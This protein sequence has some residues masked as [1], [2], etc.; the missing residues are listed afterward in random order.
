MTVQIRNA[1]PG[2]YRF[3]NDKD[4]LFLL[5]E[6]TSEHAEIIDLSFY[7]ESI[8]IGFMKYTIDLSRIIETVDNKIGFDTIFK[9]K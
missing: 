7:H 3:M 4:S 5:A 2:F 1:K 8:F 9:A 6:K